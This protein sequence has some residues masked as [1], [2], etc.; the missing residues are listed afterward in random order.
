MVM[1]IENMEYLQL[2]ENVDF[3]PLLGG[4]GTIH[5]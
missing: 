1:K 2:G 5:K 3:G 4:G